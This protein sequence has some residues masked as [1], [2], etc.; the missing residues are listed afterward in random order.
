MDWDESTENKGDED[1]QKG[2]KQDDDQN[3]WSKTWPSE[4]VQLPGK[5]NSRRLQEPKR[6]KET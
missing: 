4:T 2:R 3:R 5:H 6:D 1:K